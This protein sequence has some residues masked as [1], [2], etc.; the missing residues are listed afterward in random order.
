[1]ATPCSTPSWLQLRAGEEARLLQ[2]LRGVQRHDGHAGHVERVGRRLEVGEVQLLGPL[3][4]APSWLPGPRESGRRALPVALAATPRTRR[5]SRPPRPL[6]RAGRTRAARCGRARG[7]TRRACSP[8][9]S[10]RRDRGGSPPPPRT[11]PECCPPGG[12][13]TPAPRAAPPPRRPRRLPRSSAAS[14]DR[15]RPCPASS[16]SSIPSRVLAASTRSVSMTGAVPVIR[17][18]TR[19][20]EAVKAARTPRG[21]VP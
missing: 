5:G 11:G 16:P 20:D 6:R 17:W 1:M 19:C 8:C 13:R 21:Y 4:P 7:R 2:Q 15:R 18:A 3:V 14:A 10:A 12:V 9:S